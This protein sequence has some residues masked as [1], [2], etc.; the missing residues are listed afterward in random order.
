MINR[1]AAHLLNV[2]C[3]KAK[4]FY[5]KFQSEKPD[6]C[7]LY[8]TSLLRI[9]KCKNREQAHLFAHV[10]VYSRVHRRMPSRSCLGINLIPSAICALTTKKRLAF[11]PISLSLSEREIRITL[12]LG[13][14]LEI[15]QI[16]CLYTMSICIASTDVFL[17]ISPSPSHIRVRSALHNE[18][19]IDLLDLSDENYARLHPQRCPPA[20][21]VEAVTSQV[22][23]RGRSLCGNV[24]HIHPFDRLTAASSSSQI[25]LRSA[26][27]RRLRRRR[28]RSASRLWN[29]RTLL[30]WVGRFVV[31]RSS[32]ELVGGRAPSR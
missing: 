15:P 18:R 7:F 14:F 4:P 20:L 27:I 32:C 22:G 26:R 21:P 1:T 25:A 6:P 28:H 12:G 29:S 17:R 30:F 5:P 9:A 11:F 10:Y 23:F 8:Y 31:P 3:T 19:T 2:I 16:I 24:L 13:M